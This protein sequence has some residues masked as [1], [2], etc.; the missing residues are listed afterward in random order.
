M[1]TSQGGEIVKIAMMSAWN[2]DSG[3]AIHAEPVGRAWLE[4]GHELQVF[5]FLKDDFHGEEIT[6]E[7]LNV[8]LD[9]VNVETDVLGKWVQHLMAAPNQ[10][11]PS[12]LTVDRL[13]EAGFI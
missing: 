13:R 10:A 12:A 6:A 8:P 11:G 3:V 4:M 5:T 2:T 7:V 9:M 1:N